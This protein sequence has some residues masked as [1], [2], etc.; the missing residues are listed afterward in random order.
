M[1]SFIKTGGML[2]FLLLFV[3]FYVVCILLGEGVGGIFRQGGLP[4][5]RGIV[6]VLL[7]AKMVS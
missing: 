2:V 5:P 3:L 4:A 1:A 6:R 7:Y